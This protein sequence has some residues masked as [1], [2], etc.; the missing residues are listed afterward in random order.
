MK[1]NI[2]KIITLKDGSKYIVLDQG[3][4]NNK[5]YYITSKLDSEANLTNEINIFVNNDDYL[6]EVTDTQVKEA[7]IEYFKKR[8]E[9]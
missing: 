8:L 9:N 2:D 6:E 3:N 4:Y 7:L 1:N 5:A